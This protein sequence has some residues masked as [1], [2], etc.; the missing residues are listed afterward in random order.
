MKT[1][2]VTAW[3]WA[4]KDGYLYVYNLHATRKVLIECGG[5][6]GC[7][8]VRVTIAPAKRKRRKKS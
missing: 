8:P 3:A 7:V 5:P 1:K 2:P 6:P 4:D